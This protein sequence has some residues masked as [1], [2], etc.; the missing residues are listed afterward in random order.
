MNIEKD[1]IAEYKYLKKQIK[2]CKKQMKDYGLLTESK[3]N[4]LV[5]HPAVSNYDTFMKQFLNVCKI[6]DIDASSEDDVLKEF[7]K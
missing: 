3:A 7:I 2:L 6:L 4:G 5:R 1:L